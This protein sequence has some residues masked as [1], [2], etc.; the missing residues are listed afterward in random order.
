MSQDILSQQLIIEGD[1]T[2]FSHLYKKYVDDLYNYGLSLRVSQDVCM[3]AIHDVFYR[4][5]IDRT[6]LKDIKNIKAYLFQSIKNRLMNFQK[7]DDRAVY[8]NNI[9]DIPFSLEVSALD[10]IVDVE[11]KDFIIKRV[12]KLL[13]SLTNR[14]REAIYLRYMQELDYDEIASILNMSPASARKLV[15]RGIENLRSQT[16]NDQ[17]PTFLCIILLFP[18][19]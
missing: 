4:L 6:Q 19:A 8:F 5:Y 3:D 13:E 18:L 14:Q 15:Y 10:K 16:K 7:H 2:E 1:K 11:E 12:E 9:E 17:I